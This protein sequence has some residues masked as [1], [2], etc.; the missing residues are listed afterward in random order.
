MIEYAS[1]DN[2]PV[3]MRKAAVESI[4][5]SDVLAWTTSFSA[6]FLLKSET[7]RLRSIPPSQYNCSVLNGTF[8][9][10]VWITVMKLVQVI[11]YESIY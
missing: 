6:Y 8:A 1:N 9:C 3:Y 11:T 2:S 7:E 5:L 10:R 4:K